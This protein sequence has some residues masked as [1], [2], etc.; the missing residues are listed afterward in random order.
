MNE[1]LRKILMLLG[2]ITAIY[3]L[4]K[5][6]IP[7]LFK[8]IVITLGVVFYIIMWVAI[9][10]AVIMLIYYIVQSFKK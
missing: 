10:I 5:I 7:A 8:I 6:I 3:L 9:G 2:I 1:T 4:F